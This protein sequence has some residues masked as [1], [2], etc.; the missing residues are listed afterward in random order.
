MEGKKANQNKVRGMKK[1]EHKV[2]IAQE[3]NVMGTKAEEIMVEEKREDEKKKTQNDSGEKIQT[4]PDKTKANNTEQ[5][6]KNILQHHRKKYGKITKVLNL[7]ILLLIY[8]E[9]ENS[10]KNGR[11]KGRRDQDGG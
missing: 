9:T 10:G 6:R 11:Y 5:G 7:F 8:R 3:D 2:K 1:E 4:E